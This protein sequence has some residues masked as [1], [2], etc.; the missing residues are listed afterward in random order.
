MTAIVVESVVQ[1]K[2]AATAG[3]LT[4]PMS[5]H[6]IVAGLGNVGSRVLRELHELGIDVVGID[7]SPTARGVPSREPGGF[8]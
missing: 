1:T 8:R 2:L 5:D 4:R 7:S 3:G 6:V